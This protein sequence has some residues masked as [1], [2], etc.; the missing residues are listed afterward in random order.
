MVHQPGATLLDF[1]GLGGQRRQFCLRLALAGFQLSDAFARAGVAGLP[2]GLLG[3]QRSDA[4][5]TLL[6][7]ADQTVV[8]ALGGGQCVAG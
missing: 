7:L 4:P 2:G 6:G 5:V 3:G 1:S 8:F